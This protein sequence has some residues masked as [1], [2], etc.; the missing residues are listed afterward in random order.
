MTSHILQNMD[1]TDNLNVL[2]QMGL[3]VNSFN[4]RVP[5]DWPLRIQIIQ[6]TYE[7]DVIL[8]LQIRK[9]KL[10]EVQ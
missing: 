10:A 7:A 1:V 8:I 2:T 3:S 6:P 9:A 4:V 5:G